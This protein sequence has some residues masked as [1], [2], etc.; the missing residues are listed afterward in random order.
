MMVIERSNAEAAPKSA[1]PGELDVVRRFVNTHELDLAD[2]APGED[3][4][5][6][7]TPTALRAWLADQGLGDPGLPLP[8]DAEVR[9]AGAMRE[10]LRDLLLA[11]N[12]EP[13]DPGAVE[14]MNEIT[15]DLNCRVRF[16]QHGDCE[17]EPASRGIDR[18]LASI[19][20]IA[21]RSMAEGTWE[22]L[23][24]CRADDCKWAFYDHSKNRSATWCSMA[25]CGNRAK[26]RTYRR[27]H[28]H[29]SA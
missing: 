8:T 27:R 1:A 6:I 15:E 18:A 17:L 12:G 16:D 2:L 28:S 4:D 11:N 10:A 22:R 19:L 26:A 23:K 9:R 29:R 20:A 5:K 24:A 7:A 21:Y 14:T 13:L 25:V 3:A